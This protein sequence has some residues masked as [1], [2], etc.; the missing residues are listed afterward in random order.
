MSDVWQRAYGVTSAQA[1]LDFN[2]TG[3][4]NIQKSIAGLDPRDP[5]SRFEA[6]ALQIGSGQI[7]ISWQSVLHK[8]YQPQRSSD[9]ISWQSFDGSEET[10]G[11]PDST[12]T[13]TGGIITI[14][15]AIPAGTTQMFYRIQV[16]PSFDSDSDG[17]DDFEELLLGTNRFVADTDGDGLTD[18]Q[19]SQGF[20]L[21]NGM[22]VYTNPLVADSD[23]D[24]VNDLEE[25]APG[26]NPTNPTDGV[27]ASPQQRSAKVRLQMRGTWPDYTTPDPPPVPATLLSIGSAAMITQTV[28]PAVGNP[29]SPYFGGTGTTFPDQSIGRGVEYPFTLTFAGVSPFWPTIVGRVSGSIGN[30]NNDRANFI[31]YQVGKG[32]FFTND[33]G[34]MFAE[35]TYQSTG[36]SS[37]STAAEQQL[38]ARNRGT[39]R[40][41]SV[42]FDLDIDSLNAKTATGLPDRSLAEEDAEETQAKL[43]P[44]NDGDDNG[45]KVP[46]FQDTQVAGERD[47][48][49][50]ILEV[51]PAS[52]EWGNIGIRIDSTATAGELRLWQMDRPS[53]AKITPII[54]GTV[55]TAAQLGLGVTT[56]LGTTRTVLKFY[57]EGISVTGGTRTI[58]S[59]FTFNGRQYF[60]DKVLIQ[61]VPRA[62]LV[63]SLPVA[64]LLQDNTFTANLAGSGTVT[65]YKFEI[66]KATSLTY[67]TL[68]S[69]TSNTL[70]HRVRVAGKF[71][72][73]ATA[74]VG[75]LNIKSDEIDVEYQFPDATQILNAPTVRARMD[76]AWQDT[77]AAVTP[78][79][80]RE[81]GYFVTLDT[82]TELY[83]IAGHVVGPVVANNVGGTVPL[84]RR[85]ADSIAT[86]TPLDT[87][88]YVIASFHTHTAS[89]YRTVTRQ[90]GP[91]G[92]DRTFSV[93]ATVVVPGFVYDYV[94]VQNSVNLLFYVPPGHPLNSPAMVYSIVVP[95]RRATPP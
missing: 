38:E 57:A 76:Q 56:P 58:E 52:L 93:F 28:F 8:R 85:P 12:I 60:H 42:I 5:A 9:L 70:T 2:G 23:G 36:A 41:W 89:L 17:L 11:D 20:L 75:G 79:T 51:S 13:G 81:E 73:R 87:P 82:A 25:S 43:I 24:G 59:F 45:N 26:R 7:A 72:V 91:S 77:L 88:T 33:D 84:G 62:N 19:E 18:L 10:V 37:I 47:L 49:P 83:G 67:Y 39:G 64:T 35:S 29:L 80:R 50:I 78:T 3:M 63:A 21:S 31:V 27:P 44:V 32:Y 66:R 48:V 46:D 92:P 68:A 6:L 69:G 34:F 90:V 30:P 94:G 71:K 65:N 14:Y 16:L 40:L 61:V 86:P 95:N 1:N 54:F 53:D 55:Y 22:V 4:T 74:T 15:D